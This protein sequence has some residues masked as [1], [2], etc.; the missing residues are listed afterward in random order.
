MFQTEKCL[1]R[2]PVQG[3]KQLDIFSGLQIGEQAESI[4]GAYSYIHMN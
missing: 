1:P 2:V 4:P 3:V